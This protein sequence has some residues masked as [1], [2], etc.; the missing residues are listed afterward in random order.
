MTDQGTQRRELILQL[1]V[2]FVRSYG[3]FVLLVVVF[4]T[5]INNIY[6]KFPLY[7]GRSRQKKLTDARKY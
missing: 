6:G 4:F 1:L 3:M 7:I 5:R 2:I